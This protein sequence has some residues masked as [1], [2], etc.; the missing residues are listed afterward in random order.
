[1]HPGQ[2][3]NP[4]NRAQEGSWRSIKEN[5]VATGGKLISLAGINPDDDVVRVQANIPPVESVAG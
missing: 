5:P 4:L 3:S 1:M 2:F